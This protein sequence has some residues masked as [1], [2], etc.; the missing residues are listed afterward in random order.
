MPFLKLVLKTLLSQSFAAFIL[1]LVGIIT[2]RLLGAADRGLYVLF[3]TSASIISMLLYLGMT[4]ANVYFLNREKADHHK[5][6]SNSLSFVL[7]QASLLGAI[8]LVVEHTDYLSGNTWL[9]ED[10]FFLL[11][12]SSV[13]MLADML[14][15]GIALGLHH[16]TIF[17][18]NLVIQSALIFFAT[19][20][21]FVTDLGVNQIIFLRVLASLVAAAILVV[22]LLLASRFRFALPDVSLLGRQ[23]TFGVR[24]YIQNFVGLLNYRIYFYILAVFVDQAAVGIFSVAILLLE[25][26]RLIPEAAGTVLFPQLTKLLQSDSAD[27]FTAQV[28]RTVL[29]ITLFVSLCVFIF[30]TPIILLIFGDEYVGAISLLRIMTIG[31]TVG[32]FYQIFSRYFTSR[33]QQHK[34]IISGSVALLVGTTLSLYLIPRLGI[35]GAA[36]SFTI[37]NILAG[38][39]IMV[40]FRRSTT[41]P[42]K[43]F[44][45]VNRE[46]LAL[47]QGRL[48]SWTKP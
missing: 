26:I 17:T 36:I 6:I 34:T 39:L 2:A 28:T 38:C 7:V 1:F 8:L 46:D 42:Y 4:Q 41:L 3:F 33:F 31:V 19:V 40:L 14:F 16:Y 13:L 27:R 11:F 22:R 10:L 15:S 45:L 23:L 37:A 48:R 47:A 30:A 20:P 43:T 44:L 29:F 9:T 25:A 18:Q 35:L 21:L 24:N 5:I 12:I 32:I